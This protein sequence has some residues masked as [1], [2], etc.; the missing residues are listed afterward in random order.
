MTNAI[1]HLSLIKKIN[2]LNIGDDYIQISNEHLNDDADSDIN[3]TSLSNINQFKNN[4]Q[5]DE[6][7]NNIADCMNSLNFFIQLTNNK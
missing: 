1:N 2:Q 3:S 5:D 4:E 6:K 7:F